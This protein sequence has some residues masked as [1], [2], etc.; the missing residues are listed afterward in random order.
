[1]ATSLPTT[2]APDR[3]TSST[4]C[5]GRTTAR[6]TSALCASST[7]AV[8]KSTDRGD[9]VPINPNAVGDSSEPAERSWTSKD[10]LLYAVGVGAGYPDRL[11]ELQFTTENSHDVTQQALPTMAVVLN[12]RGGGAMRNVGSFN[13]MFLVHGEQRIE[14]HQPLPVEGSVTMTSTITGI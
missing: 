3:W 6:S 1:A 5:R 4:D 13:P 2:S 7:D 8:N 12:A 14:L 11:D 10:A 9:C